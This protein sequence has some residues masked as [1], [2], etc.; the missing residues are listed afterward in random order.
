METLKHVGSLDLS[1]ENDGRYHVVRKELSHDGDSARAGGDSI[2]VK[3]LRF[4]KV[5]FFSEN[6]KG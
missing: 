1:S 6:D 4:S 2:S 5:G 3:A